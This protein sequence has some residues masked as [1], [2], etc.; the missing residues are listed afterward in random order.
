MPFHHRLPEED[1]YAIFSFIQSMNITF[2]M[3][4]WEQVAVILASRP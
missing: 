1:K 4:I 2:G 3:T